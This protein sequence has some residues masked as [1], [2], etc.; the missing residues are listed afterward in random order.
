MPIPLAH[1]GHS[2]LQH[3]HPHHARL[4]RSQTGQTDAP[5]A[6]LPSP[7][8]AKAAAVKSRR[9]GAHPPSAPARQ[10]SREQG[11][12]GAPRTSVLTLGCSPWGPAHHAESKGWL[13]ARRCT[14][15]RI[16]MVTTGTGVFCTRRREFFPAS[17]K[18][19]T[20]TALPDHRGTEHI[21]P[22]NQLC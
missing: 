15:H 12:R 18:D 20:Q 7:L 10:E 16:C 8:I 14:D 9:S 11:S 3:T 6:S 1:C 5:S 21:S 2:W 4:G 17:E 13:G 22:D 19:W